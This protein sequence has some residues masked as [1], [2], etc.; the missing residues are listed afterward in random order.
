M[1]AGIVLL[2]IALVAVACLQT[3]VGNGVLK[4]ASNPQRPC[5]SGYY[6]SSGTCWKNGST[7]S[8]PDMAIAAASQHQGDVCGSDA[9][10]DTSHCVDGVC[11]DS[12]CNGQCQACDVGAGICAIVS[13]TPH[14]KRPACSGNGACASACNGASMTCTYPDAA[15]PCGPQTCSGAPPA[16]TSASACNG[17][18]SCLPMGGTTS[19]N[20]PAP[21]GGSATCSGAQCDFICSAPYQRQGSSCV[22]VFNTE[23]ANTGGK[24]IDFYS[25]WG[26][27]SNN[28]FIGGFN[29]TDSIGVIFWNNGGS[30]A[31]V[32]ALP[33]GA[34]PIQ[35]IW[36]DNANDIYAVGGIYGKVYHSTSPGL[37]PEVQSTG[38]FD[39][40]EAIWGSGN[41]QNVWVVGGTTSTNA[42]AIV[43]RHSG[44]AWSMETTGLTGQIRLTGVWGAGDN[45][46]YAVCNDGRIIHTTGGGT[47]GTPQQFSHT[48]NALQ[49]IWGADSTHI[50]AVGAG[51]TLV[52]TSGNGQWGAQPSGTVSDLFGVW[53]SSGGDVYAVGANGVILHSTGDGKWQ[54]QTSNTTTTLRAVWGTGPTNVYAV[55]LGGT[56][57][58]FH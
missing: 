11:C 33:N 40:Y 44:A 6:C 55:G 12:S 32:S 18:G 51:G 41:F 45:D 58:H 57:T 27:A 30:F 39:S 29:T 22:A 8:T 10:C 5:P 9:D 24:V 54:P 52:F 37:F 21:F 4:C 53:G 25:V 7:P 42:G 13:G 47:W 49:A 26:S 2:A 36:G 3:T 19:M 20:C 35:G 50:W 23:N 1:R 17:A 38:I 15:T 46:V 56:I 48:A 43:N 28:T 16:I 31:P 14:G 34:P